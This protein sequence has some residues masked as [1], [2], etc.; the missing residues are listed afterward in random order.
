MP[1]PMGYDGGRSLWCH[2][3]PSQQKEGSAGFRP[4]WVGGFEILV[5][6]KVVR[7]SVGELSCWDNLLRGLCTEMHAWCQWLIIK[8][9]NDYRGLK[10]GIDGSGNGVYAYCHRVVCWW[11]WRLPPPGKPI[12]HHKCSRV[13]QPSALGLGQ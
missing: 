10:V 3:W 9:G 8:I 7:M 13:L 12:A 4:H 1:L 11:A 2:S 6:P 5:R